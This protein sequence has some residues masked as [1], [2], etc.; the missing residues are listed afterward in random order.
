MGS[1]CL[2]AVLSRSR[3]VEIT[4][5]LAALRNADSA[6]RAHRADRAPRVLA[7]SYS[8]FLGFPYITNRYIQRAFCPFVI[9]LL[10]YDSPF[11]FPS[12][13]KLP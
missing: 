7:L 12:I 8:R 1:V 5:I 13:T 10:I 6:P 2:S 4:A 9:A 11:D 3:V